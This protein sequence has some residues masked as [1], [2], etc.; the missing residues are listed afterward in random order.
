[1]IHDLAQP[2]DVLRAIR[3][4]L[5]QE[6][7]Y[8]MIDIAASSELGDNLDHPLATALYT[9]SL[10]HCMT[11]SLAQGGAG[12]GTM[13]GEQQARQLLAGAGFVNVDVE[14]IPADP[15]KQLLYRAS[16][17]GSEK[18]SRR[19]RVSA[20]AV[21][22]QVNAKDQYTS[23]SFAFFRGSDCAPNHPG[24]ATVTSM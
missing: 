13:W 2:V 20:A 8:F 12:L 9:V 5:K 14:R 10:F 6:G 15:F 16:I 19:S 11:V 1:M 3:R 23:R 24:T 22:T 7:V 18:R 17:G 4:A 21:R